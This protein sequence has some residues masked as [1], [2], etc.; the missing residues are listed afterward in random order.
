[1]GWKNL[2]EDPLVADALSNFNFIISD[3]IHIIPK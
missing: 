1:M 2:F 3:L